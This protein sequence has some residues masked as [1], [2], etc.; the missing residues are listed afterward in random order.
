[1]D[2]TFEDNIDCVIMATG[3]TFCFPFVECPSFEVKKNEVNLYKLVFPPDLK[4]ST[5]CVIGCAQPWGAIH[6]ISELQ[7]RW[8]TRVFKGLALLPTQ[9]EMEAAIKLMKDEMNKRYKKSQRH[10]IQVD[11]IKY[12]DTIASEFGVKPDLFKLFFTDPLLA[13]RCYFGPC[14]PYQ[15]RLMGPGKWSGAK[16]AINTVYDRIH[17]PLQTRICNIQKK[18]RSTSRLLI[19]C[20]LV[21]VLCIVVA[22]FL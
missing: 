21:I 8:A 20:L 6:P 12:M 11:W 19:L 2:G 5:I 9:P 7:S 15:Y 10:T 1:M 13:L 18:S 4:H 14:V 3:Y 22:K 17:A 16:E